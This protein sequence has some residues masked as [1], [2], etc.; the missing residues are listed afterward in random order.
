MRQ[1]ERSRDAQTHQ[2]FNDQRVLLK[3]N[4]DGSCASSETVAFLMQY[5]LEKHQQKKREYRLL[6]EGPELC[7][8]DNGDVI[9]A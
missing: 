7:G 3:D 9:R 8:V 2:P 6:T 1:Q 4:C 5:R